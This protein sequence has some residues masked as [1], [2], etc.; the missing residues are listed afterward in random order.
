MHLELLWALRWLRR[1]P[2]FTAATVFVLAL[3]IGANTAVFSIVDAVLLRPSP[4]PAAERLVRIEASTTSRT[5]L[6]ALVN[7][8][9]RW[10]GRTDI[11]EKTAAYLR[12]TVTLTG[13][14][15]PEQVIAVRA[16][17]LFPVLG[18]P[19]R[20]G[21]TLIPSDDQV[22][23]QNVAVLSNRIW[24]RRY[25]SD[26]NVIGRAITISEEP[27]T[28]VGV[29][30]SD[31]EFRYSEAELW[32]PLRL[33]P[34][35]PWVQVAGRL[36][37]GVSLA[38]ARS[39]FEILAHQIEQEAPNDHAGLKILVTQWRDTPDQK[40]KLTLIFVLVAVGLMMLIVCADVGGLLLTR[41]VQRQ[42]EISIRASL[43]AGL[44]R[45]VRQL[46][47]E[48]LL[49]A[50]LG[51]LAGIVVAWC[52]LALLTKQLAALPIVLPH[53][54]QVGLNGRVL[55][56][57]VVL[58]LLLAILCGL[59]PTLLAVR[60]DLQGVLRSGSGSGGLRSSWR[61]FSVLI[62]LEAGFAFLLLV[63]SG[64]MIRS[65]IRLQQ[66]DHGFRPDHV[67]TLRVPVGT[68][69]QPR[70]TGKYNTR[71]RQIAYYRQVLERVKTVPGI[72][73]AAIVNNPPLSDINSSLTFGLAGPDGKPQPTS[74]RCISPEYFAAMGIPVI[75][76]RTFADTDQAG[77][78]EVAII[79]EYLARQLF[80][81][82]SPLGER[83]GGGSTASGPMIVGVVKD[84]AQRSYELPPTSEVYIPYQQYIFA[85]FM[86]TI[87]VRT[88]GE[89][90]AFA[91]ALRKQVWAVDPNQPVVKVETMEEMIANSIWRPRF[92]AWIFGVLSGL[93]VILAAMGV[94]GVVAYTS[95]LRAREIGI[96][97]ALGA[98][99]NNVLAVILRG[100]MIPLLCGIGL[101]AVAA[102][103]LSRLLTDLLYGISGTDPF[104][105]FSAG[106]LL[107]TI[108]TAASAHP[109]WRAATCDPLETLRSE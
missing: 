42:K 55:V 40:Y 106:I 47:S 23:S 81:N 25:H 69:T 86:S 28:I 90:A 35:Y 41:A 52:L 77:A 24:R 15:E 17:G 12:D 34:A 21:R 9:Q 44:W 59:A 78:P 33:T 73:A 84:A 87:V 91:P 19:A 57:N 4:F 16:L 2:L 38:Q 62:A 97:V 95:A 49:L 88:E 10:A 5:L 61:L 63:G 68:V 45:I 105:Y 27:Y 103:L 31:F 109:A 6:G 93:S 98:S 108:G 65:L 18:T 64:L 99:T 1:N 26:P 102:L 92:S 48:T 20:L 37:V 104:S 82:R 8:Y 79:N 96:R 56:F 39:A 46:L 53:L 51:S 76:G 30:P 74:A 7:D 43:G 89:P 14:P 3:G 85:T 71:A 80:P 22:G 101:S 75:A 67:L 13:N 60:T 36:R 66:E 29:M 72:K 70:P 11:L 83:L 54:Q 100:A 58:C 50:V 32:I 94:Y 107:L